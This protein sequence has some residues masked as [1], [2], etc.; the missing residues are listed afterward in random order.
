MLVY[1][2]E[3]RDTSS[4]LASP[5]H[6]LWRQYELRCC[7]PPA[8]GSSSQVC[9]WMIAFAFSSTTSIQKS[10]WD[11]PFGLL[12]VLPR[13]VSSAVRHPHVRSS[14]GVEMR[15]GVHHCSIDFS[16]KGKEE[17]K[18]YGNRNI[19]TVVLLAVF[20]WHF[21]AV[22]CRIPYIS[23]YWFFVH[24]VKGFIHFA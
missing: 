22:Y 7:W 11:L 6:P 24:C 18:K 21:Y 10:L 14:A 15:K 23:S 5:V 3:N 13:S 8:L 19:V 4:T 1:W 9:L 2:F 20:C 12:V 17:M 16:F